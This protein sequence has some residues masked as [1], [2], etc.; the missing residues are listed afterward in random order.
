VFPV[1]LASD[2]TGWRVACTKQAPPHAQRLSRQPRPFRHLS[3]I[4]QE[5]LPSLPQQRIDSLTKLPASQ[6]LF[7]IEPFARSQ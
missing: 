5:R 6:S 4:T 2:K 3:T 1:T 7:V